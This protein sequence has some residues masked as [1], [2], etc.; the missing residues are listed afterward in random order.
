MIPRAAANR[1]ADR[2][3][4][5]L[6]I[7][8]QEVVLLYALNA[9]HA[10]GL[11]G[12]L[13]FKGGTYLR[14]MVTGDAG[15]LSEDLDF[16]SLGLPEDP[17]GLLREAFAPEH[18]GVQFS[19]VAPYRTAR[20]NW[21]C[22]VGYHHPWDDGEF[23]L[24]ISYRERPFLSPRRWAP[25]AQPYF[26]ALPFPPPQIP[27]LRV[28]ESLAEKLRAIQ[29]RATERDLYDA[30]RYARKG[31]DEGLVRLLAVGKLWN[32]REAFDPDQIL[33]T[34]S[35]GRRDWPDLERL[36]GRSRRRDWNREAAAAGRRFGFLRDLTPFEQE[37][38]ADARRHALRAQ[39]ERQLGMFG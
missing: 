6:H 39:L 24:E 28:E 34:L 11:L 35:E 1:F 16:T 2:M 20:R 26:A 18:H 37:L 21:A 32:D 10:A 29:Q 12:R 27:C 23:R 19:V 8:Q 31:F 25:L 17:E 3:G 14:L 30:T 33:R 5:D 9:L 36:I 38:R 15:R 13:V 22:R 4:V 7:A